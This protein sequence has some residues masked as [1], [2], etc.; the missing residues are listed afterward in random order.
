MNVNHLLGVLPDCVLAGTG[1]GSPKTNQ[2]K[3]IF[4]ICKINK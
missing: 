1:A 2:E 3:E 4:F